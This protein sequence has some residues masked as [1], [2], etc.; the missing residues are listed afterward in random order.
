MTRVRIAET[1]NDKGGTDFDF[2]GFP[3]W[4]DFEILAQVLEVFGARKIDSFEAVYLR[5]RVYEIDDL[6]FTLLHHDEFGNY[7]YA[8]NPTEAIDDAL[9]KIAN[10]VDVK[11]RT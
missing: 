2:A 4:E 9:R 1:R 8:E 3:T 5:K 7:M 10:R 6:L 11:L